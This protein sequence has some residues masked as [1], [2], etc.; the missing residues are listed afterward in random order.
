MAADAV[1]LLDHLGIE[2]AHIVGASMGGMI[3]QTMAIEHPDRV[4]T[5]TSI[6]STTGEPEYGQAEPEAMTALLD[7]A[8]API[9]TA[10][11][12]RPPT[13]PVVSPALLRRGAGHAERAGGVRPRASTRR[14]RVPARWRSSPSGDRTEALR[15]ASTCRPS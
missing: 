1:G 4:L 12:A 6:M 10:Y 9:A 3:V 5:L 8:T 13:R 7:P 15:D 14:D 11:I 2:Q